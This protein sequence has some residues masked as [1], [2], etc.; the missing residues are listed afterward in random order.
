M[1]PQ[2]V[3]PANVLVPKEPFCATNLKPMELSETHVADNYL[4][5]KHSIGHDAQ[6]HLDPYSDNTSSE[7][8]L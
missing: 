4:G 3:N 8:L 7:L 2:T 1:S 6:N 5:D